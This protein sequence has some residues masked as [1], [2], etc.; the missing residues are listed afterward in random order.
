LYTN[1]TALQGPAGT[2]SPY[3]IWPIWS[4]AAGNVADGILFVPEG[5][6]YSPPLFLGAQLLAINCT[7]GKLVWSQAAFD[8]DSHPITVDGIMTDL[9]AY[10]NEIYAYAQG[11]S[12]TT[13]TAPNVGV[14]TATPITIRGTVT[15]ISPGAS[16]EVVAADYPNGL[17]C[18]SDASM[19]PFMEAVYDQQPM[20][21]NLTGVPVTISV[22]DSNHN[23]YV[24]GTAI[25]SPTTGEYSLTWTPD[26]PGNY[27]VAAIFAGTGGYY[28]STAQTAFYAS[29]PAATTAPTA[30]PASGLASNNTLMY[31]GVAIIIVIIIIGAVLAILVTR[32][33]P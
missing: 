2:N 21:T 11:P 10:N 27:T 3:G 14:T 29:S 26:I 24:I 28:G 12:K 5:H 8:V 31:V 9:N 18:V 15:D 33:H 32:K 7:N 25:S 22:T 4:F 13:V 6:E 30:A 19:T 16:Q 20:P 1:T 23:T 17:P